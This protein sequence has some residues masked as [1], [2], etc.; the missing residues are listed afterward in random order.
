MIHH[1]S[2]Y[3]P[4]VCVTII[5]FL[6]VVSA[7]FGLHLRAAGVRTAFLYA[8]IPS[9]R[10]VYMKPPSGSDCGDDEVWKLKRVIYGLPSVP[11]TKSLTQYVC[12]IFEVVG[13]QAMHTR[14]V[15]VHS[16]KKTR[17]Y[18]HGYHL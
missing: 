10:N 9:R 7:T 4:V 15:L 3:A 16:P 12:G 14:P 8:E 11:C 1:R 5:R 2:M 18:H 13:T 6:L 17:I